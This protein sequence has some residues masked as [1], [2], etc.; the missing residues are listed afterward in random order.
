MRRIILLIILCL[1]VL[2]SILLSGSKAFAKENETGNGVILIGSDAAESGLNM[3]EKAKS[4]Y[5]M[6]F[7]SQTVIY[8]RDECARH[9]IASMTKIMLLNLIFDAVKQNKLSLDED[10]VVSENASAMGGSQVFLQADKT[11]KASDLV[12]SVIVASA[13]DAS[14]AMAERLYGS[15][16][17]CVEAMNAKRNEFGMTNT[18]FANVTGLPHVSQYSCAKDVAAMFCHLLNYNDYFRYSD[19]YLDYLVHPDGSK[20]VLTNTNKLVKFYNGCDGGKTGYTSEAGS[21]LAVTAKRDNMRIVA[22][23]IGEPDSKTRNGEVSKMLDYAFNNFSSRKILS[24]DEVLFQTKSVQGAKNDLIAGCAS[25]YCTFAKKGENVNF[26]TQIIVD[27]NLKAPILCG[28]K[29]G[30]VTVYVDGVKRADIDLVAKVNVEKK[31]VIDEF[32]NLIKQLKIA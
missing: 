28:D 5:L 23:V 24:K 18:L 32:K 25:D 6:D 4:C 21:C 9:Q 13:N 8:Q 15:E 22:V 10:I 20:T 11:Y 7:G 17:A 29:I 16:N 19:I 26:E 12:K 14:V 1:T 2:S 27:D 30:V 3:A 31:T